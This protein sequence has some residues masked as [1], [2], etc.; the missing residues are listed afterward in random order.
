VA[1]ALLVVPLAGGPSPA[2]RSEPDPPILD[3]VAGA[4][5]STTEPVLGDTAYA[6]T[7]AGAA[8]VT[9][10]TAALTSATCD[11]CVGESTALH[12]VYVPRASRATLDNVASA[13]AQACEGCTSTALSVQVVV[14]AGRP[15]TL[16]SNRALSVTAGCTGCRTA[17]RAFQ[18]VLLTDRAAPMPPE[19]LAAVRAWAD[20]QAAEL[21]AAVTDPG[22]LATPRDPHRRRWRTASA[23][24]ELEVLLTGAL[25]ATTVAADVDASR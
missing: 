8:D 21:R 20:Q 23:L 9:V 12:V 4:H 18:L 13:W 25:D 14:V 15:V 7:R 11:G 17:A 1:G 22:A 5:P 19:E 16:P 6:E 3:L 24:A 10:D 2:A